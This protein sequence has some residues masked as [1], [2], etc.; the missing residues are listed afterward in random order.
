MTT[1]ADRLAQ[2]PSLDAL[3]ALAP[4]VGLAPGWNKP[5][6]SL[7]PEPR[8]TFPARHWRYAESKSGLDAAGRLMT[9][10]DAERRNLVLVN[11]TPGNVYATTRTIVVAYQMILPGERARILARLPRRAARAGAR[12]DVL[13]AVPRRLSRDHGDAPALALRFRVARHR[14]RARTR[15]PRS[16]RP[17]RSSGAA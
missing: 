14:S 10:A 8:K 16:R 2:A 17:V 11:P 3:Y 9:T 5:T 4:E 12:A 6:P 13:R 7:W 1:L 15:C